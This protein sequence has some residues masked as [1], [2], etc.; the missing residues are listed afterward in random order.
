M[1]GKS[2]QQEGVAGNL[3]HNR[4]GV[5]KNGIDGGPSLTSGTQ[6]EI[7][8]PSVHPWGGG[9][10]GWISQGISSCGRGI[11]TRETCALHTARLSCDTLVDFWSALGEETRRSLLRMKKILSK[12]SLTG[13]TD[14]EEDLEFEILNCCVLVNIRCH[15]GVKC[16]SWC[17]YLRFDSKRFCRDCRRNIIREFKEFKELKRMH[18]EP[19]CTSWFCAADTA[20]LY[21]NVQLNFS[22][23]YSPVGTVEGKSVIMEFENVG[24]SGSARVCC[25]DLDGLSSCYITLRAWKLDGRCSEISVKAHALKGQQCVHCRLVVGDGYVTITR[26]VET[27]AHFFMMMIPWTRMEMRSMENASVPKSMRKS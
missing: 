4:S 12:G 7:H 11:G 8:D 3:N 13:K 20:F 6:D 2:L 17:L 26:D 27:L 25:L 21:E 1:Y 22:L 23:F 19:R 5:S 16:F 9:G 14:W 10:R 24:M 18:R 15:D